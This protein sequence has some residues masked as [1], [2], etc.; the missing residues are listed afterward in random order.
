M[1]CRLVIS[2]L[3][4]HP[5]CHPYRYDPDGRSAAVHSAVTV[6]SVHSPNCMGREGRSQIEYACLYVCVVCAVVYVMCADGFVL[7]S[8]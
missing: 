5:I 6:C 8:C 4:L 1:Y 7:I 3:G 2:C